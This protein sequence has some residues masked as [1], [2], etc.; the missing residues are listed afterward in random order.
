MSRQQKRAVDI[1]YDDLG[2]S[3]EEIVAHFEQINT[4]LKRIPF[5]AVLGYLFEREGEAV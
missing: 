4:G 3:P 2:M 1:C 5:G